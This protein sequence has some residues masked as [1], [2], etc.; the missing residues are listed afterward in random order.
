L[1]TSRYLLERFR[2]VFGNDF[3][4]VGMACGLSHHF[5][6]PPN[7]HLPPCRPLRTP[8]GQVLTLRNQTLV[9]RTGEQGYAVLADLV[10]EV[11]T[12]DADA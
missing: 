8:L 3:R 2:T 11:L 9:N 12:S 1:K 10:A 6:T 5:R 7:H 4:S